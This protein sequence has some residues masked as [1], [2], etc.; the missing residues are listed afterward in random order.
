LDNG[1]FKTASFCNISFDDSG[2][3]H[4][5]SKLN[6][7]KIASEILQQRS[8][9]G[10]TG[11]QLDLMQLMLKANEDSAEKGSSKLTDEQING[12]CQIFLF[13]GYET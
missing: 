12:R 2:T 7:K 9:T 3:N 1:H 5:H 4:A 10:P 13:A 8:K 6:F 11:R